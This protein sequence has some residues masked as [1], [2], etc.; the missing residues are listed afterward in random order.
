MESLFKSDSA[1]IQVLGL[2]V[3]SERASPQSALMLVR[4]SA[5][6]R[7]WSDSLVGARP[8]EF[9]RQ[10]R[11]AAHKSSRSQAFRSVPVS[12]RATSGV[13]KRKDNAAEI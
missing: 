7:Y 8:R 1:E 9:S 6:A 2:A 12:E 10:A 13:G 11:S 5:L 3:V 4:G